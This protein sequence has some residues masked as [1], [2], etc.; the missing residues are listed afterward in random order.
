MT[1]VMLWFWYTPVLHQFITFSAFDT[2]IVWSMDVLARNYCYKPLINCTCRFFMNHS[3][4]FLCCT[5]TWTWF[6]AFIMTS[7]CTVSNVVTGTVNIVS[8]VVTNCKLC[9]FLLTLI[10]V[11]A[12]KACASSCPQCQIICSIY[13][14][15]FF[16][17]V[18]QLFH[19]RE[20]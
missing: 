8:S 2:I 9:Q 11:L 17:K 7:C 5:V 15:E 18:K 13:K 10:H 3:L 19:V 1:Y 6:K 16:Y 14:H 12:K 4:L 20:R